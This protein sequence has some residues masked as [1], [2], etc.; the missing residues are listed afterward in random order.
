MPILSVPIPPDAGEVVVTTTDADGRLTV[1]GSWPD[2]QRSCANGTIVSGYGPDTIASITRGAPNSGVWSGER[3]S[4]YR[5]GDWNCELQVAFELRSTARRFRIVET[6]TALQDGT[7]VFTRTSR[8]SI[9][10]R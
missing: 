9:M 3:V 6:I 2:K 10:R 5:R 4:R 1:K 8:R 7:A